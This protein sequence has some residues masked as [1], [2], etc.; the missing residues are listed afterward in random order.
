MGPKSQVGVG[1]GEQLGRPCRGRS[2]CMPASRT[3][4]TR[5]G[6]STSILPFCEDAAPAARAATAGGRAVTFLCLPPTLPP[7]PGGPEEAGEAAGQGRARRVSA[8]ARSAC[9]AAAAE[10]AA[11]PWRARAAAAAAAVRHPSFGGRRTPRARSLEL[12][13]RAHGCNPRTKQPRGT[14]HHTRGEGRGGTLQEAG[15][16]CAITG[17]GRCGGACAV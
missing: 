13:P 12:L 1:G 15:L 6:S 11:G 8:A 14:F 4:C 7:A 17:G 3:Y 16:V 2:R 10:A 5:E 9:T